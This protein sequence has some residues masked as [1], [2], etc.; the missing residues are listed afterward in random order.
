MSIVVGVDPDGRGRAV[1]DLAAMLARSSGD[2][3]LLCTVLA[4]AW[5]PGPARVDAE[6]RARLDHLADA[7][8][9]RAAGRVPRD[10][11]VERV[12]HHA[13]SA[14]S[15]L[16]EVA[17]ERGASMLV[18]GALG[19]VGSR[20]MHSSPLPV[21]LAPRGWRAPAAARVARITAAY[22]GGPDDLVVAARGVAERVGAELRVVS[23]A[24]HPHPPY[25]AGVGHVADDA[26]VAEW[27]AAIQA[28]VPDGVETVVG[29]GESWEE[30]LE[31]VDWE[32]AE[33]LVVGSSSSG[34]LARVFLGSRSS[35]IVQHSP[36]PVVVVPR[37]V[38]V[39]LAA[40]AA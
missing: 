5:P 39:E 16:L 15:G 21:A 20:L 9:A 40:E 34:P 30:A 10:V 11:T 4:E 12:I 24:V 14:P 29:H 36:V 8:L 28:A 38:A 27:S 22:A 35:R 25:T 2:D 18:V 32:P 19:S 33:V 23:F 3:L 13:R 1:L 37:P 26:M 6:Y 17:E 7:A 31:D